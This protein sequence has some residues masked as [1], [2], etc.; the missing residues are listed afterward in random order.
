MNHPSGLIPKLN[1]IGQVIGQFQTVTGE[2]F[3]FVTAANGGTLTNLEAAPDI[4]HA[5][6]SHL[7]VS[8]INNVG[9]I[10]G[11]GTIDGT[12]RAFLLSPVPEPETYALMLAGLGLLGGIARRRK[13]RIAS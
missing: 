12:V 1:D 11:T 2:S 9:Q 7:F 4:V 5:G 8:D 10:T 3:A 13:A 6:W